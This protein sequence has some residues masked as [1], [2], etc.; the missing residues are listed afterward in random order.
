VSSGHGKDRGSIFWYLDEYNYLFR[1]RQNTPST[2]FAR[3]HNFSWPPRPRL[4][5]RGAPCTVLPVLDWHCLV[6]SHHCAEIIA[7]HLNVW[8]AFRNVC[9]TD[10]WASATGKS[11]GGVQPD[12][13]IGHFRA[14]LPHGDSCATWVRGSHLLSSEKVVGQ[15]W[16]ADRPDLAPSH[17]ERHPSYQDS[18]GSWLVGAFPK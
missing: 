10:G 4:H 9:L 14:G 16:S 2:H 11:R 8:V 6:A 12:V 1:P 17:T 13:V 5:K 18:I 7:P 15:L 3:N